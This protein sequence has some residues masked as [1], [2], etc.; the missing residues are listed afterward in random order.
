VGNRPGRP[1]PLWYVNQHGGRDGQ[2]TDSPSRLALSVLIGMAAS[3]CGGS[4]KPVADDGTV[5]G[6]A[7]LLHGASRA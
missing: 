5:L 7:A 4:N 1:G 2:A 6:T 3:G